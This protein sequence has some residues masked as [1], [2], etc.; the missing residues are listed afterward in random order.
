MDSPQASVLVVEKHPLM[1][2]ALCLAIQEEPLLTVY[3]PG[4]DEG[5]DHYTQKSDVPNL[6]LFSVDTPDIKDIQ[7]IQAVRTTF[8]DIPI[9]LIAALISP[10]Q[11]VTL[12][13]LEKIKVLSGAASCSDFTQ[14]LIDLAS[15]N[16]L[17]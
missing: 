3:Q 10:E 4:S 17:Y 1:R 14:A 5:D 16:C 12:K 15:L 2:E 7:A 11:E 13:K 9:L 8:P 6:V